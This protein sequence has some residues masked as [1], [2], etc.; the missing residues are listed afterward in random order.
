MLTP[1]VAL[2]VHIGSSPRVRVARFQV[3]GRVPFHYPA[4]SNLL[5]LLLEN[6]CDVDLA[7]ALESLALP[8]TWLVKIDSLSRGLNTLLPRRT[9]PSPT[10][11]NFL[12][13]TPWPQ[14][15]RPTIWVSWLDSF[16]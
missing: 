14:T 2:S 9:T 12:F 4:I 7:S 16:P 8:R 11:T 5:K 3:I 6:L 15:Y 10:I 1:T 13:G